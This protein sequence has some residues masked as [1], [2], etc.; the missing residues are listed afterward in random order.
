MM[1]A[2]LDDIFREI[3][4]I[5]MEARTKGFKRRPVWPMIILRT[6]KGWTGP[7]KVDGVQVEGT[8]RA[9]Q[10][11]LAEVRTDKDH[12]KM[13]EAWMR[14]YKPEKLF[15]EHGRPRPEVRA[16][17]PTGERR[18]GANPHANGGVLLRDLL[19][20]DFR[21]Y[22]VPVDQ[23]GTVTHEPTRV[24]GTWLRDVFAANADHSNFRL[25]GPDETASNR[26]GAVYEVTDKVWEGEYSP[27]DEH[28]S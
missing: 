18:M 24:L 7:K 14:S 21:E 16:V 17:A 13:L 5:Q 10:V 20:P 28:L 25:F 27:L 4:Q 12:L 6:P 19:L 11:P 26:L 15:D 8:W 3:R 23:P 2:V 1:A 9:H 22:G